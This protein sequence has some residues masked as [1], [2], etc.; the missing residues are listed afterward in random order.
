M[1][2]GLLALQGAAAVIWAFLMFRT[3]FRLRARAVD[4]SGQAFP[5]VGATLES[6]RA[7]LTEPAFARDRR[8]LGGATVALFATIALFALYRPD[9]P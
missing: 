4:R 2:G 7:F 6:Y 5:G 1:T 3:L 9:Q 8:L